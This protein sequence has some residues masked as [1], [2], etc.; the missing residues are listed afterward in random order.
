MLR[1][2]CRVKGNALWLLGKRTVLFADAAFLNSLAL[3]S[4]SLDIEFKKK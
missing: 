2:S 4:F 3:F 1:T